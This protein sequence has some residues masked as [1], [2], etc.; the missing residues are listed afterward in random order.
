MDHKYEILKCRRKALGLTKEELAEK[1][2][3]NIILIE[4]FESGKK[5]SNVEKEKINRYLWKSF[6]EMDS[7]THYKRRIL[8]L[9]LELNE[10]YILADA[11]KEIGH[12]MVELGKLQME[13]ANGGSL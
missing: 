10:E 4:A 7:I 2:G 5:I 12:M 9:A 1:S 11:I 3:V 6:Q 8:E 13:L